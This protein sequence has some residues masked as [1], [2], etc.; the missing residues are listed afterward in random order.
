[1]VVIAMGP[2]VAT[3]RATIYRMLEGSTLE[4]SLTE[5]RRESDEHF[6]VQDLAVDERP[7]RLVS[8]SITTSAKWSNDLK[9]LTGKTI[10]FLNTSP[11]AALLIQDNKNSIWALTW[12]TGFHFLDPEQIDFGFGAG[13]VARAAL[14]SEIKSI[15]KTILD[16]RARVDR[17]SMPNGSTIRDLGVDGYGEVVSRIE[18][19][20]NIKDLAVGDK[21]IQLRASDSLNLPLAKEPSR[22]IADLIALDKLSQQPVLAGLESLEQLI[23]LKPRDSR[24]PALDGK[25]VDALLSKDSQRL[26]VSWPHERLDA[27]G[28]VM[29][30]KVI[31][32]GDYK[33]RIY[34]QAPDISDIHQWLASA[35]PADILDR[36]K[37]VKIELHNDAD[38]GANTLVSNPVP[39]RRWLAFEVEDNKQRFC[40]HDGSWYRMDDQYLARIDERVEEILAESPSLQPPA[41]GEVHEDEYNKRAAEDLSGYCL[42]R[43]LITTPLHSRG[44]IEPCD[45]FVPPGI[46]IHV[47]RGRRSSDLS[48]LLAQALVSTDALARDENARAAWKKR[49]A[50]ESGAAVTD[51]ELNEVI[52][53]IGSKHPVTPDS[54][55]TF[56]KVNLVK[57]FDALRYL[58]VKVH[59]TTALPPEPNHD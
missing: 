39:L 25:L 40:L 36:I 11:G 45:V 52:I 54:L 59:V 49:I 53:V 1:M 34:E 55:F 48:H 26:G 41:W 57:Q 13:I 17:S 21:I 22:L 32:L 9:L 19:K 27:F 16:H 50:D 3:K 46:L 28:P 35:P 24:V 30:A 43:K 38:P 8:G 5:P 10:S 31:G 15:T 58:G 4:T 56:T 47:K 2:A 29:S 7:A 18:S 33:R 37:S 12:G 51:A 44:G 14:P 23:A 42:D 20:A 6:I